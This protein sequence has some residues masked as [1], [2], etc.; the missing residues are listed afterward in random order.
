MQIQPPAIGYAKKEI[1]KVSLHDQIAELKRLQSKRNEKSYSQDNAKITIDSNKPIGIVLTSDWHIGSE[2]TDYET[3]E[4]HMELIKNE[5]FAFMACL[6]NTIDNYIWPGGMFSELV[7][8]SEQ[9]EII[10]QF[11]HDYKNKII[12]IVG[13]RCHEGW[14]SDKVGLN[15]NEIMFRE[16]IDDGTPWLSKGGVVEVVLNGITYSFGLV[17]KARFHSALNPTNANKRM[18]DLRW[19][20]DISAIAHHHVANIEQT[21]RWEGPYKKDVVLVRTGTYKIKDG[22]SEL[23]GFGQGQV[24]GTMVILFPDTKKIIPFMRIEDGMEYLKLLRNG[25]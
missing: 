14:T 20:V 7:D 3:W 18:M 17:H 21:T 24:G 11:A 25:N 19:P 15:P 8:T 12:A 2:G 10:K 23:E 5:P 6:S 9:Q 13:S 4:R 1:V 22:Y 16:V